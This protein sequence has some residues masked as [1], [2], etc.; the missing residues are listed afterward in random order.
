MHILVITP[1]GKTVKVD[2]N[3]EAEANGQ[4]EKNEIEILKPNPTQ[5]QEEPTNR[6]QEQKETL[7]VGKIW[8]NKFELCYAV[9]VYKT[10]YILPVFPLASS[11]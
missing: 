11:S 9:A 1:A 10:I 3:D 4:K 7:Q 2:V 6:V 5:T 8:S